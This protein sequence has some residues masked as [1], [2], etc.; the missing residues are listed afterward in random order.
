MDS[1]DVVSLF[2]RR[3][4]PKNGPGLILFGSVAAPAT[5]NVYMVMSVGG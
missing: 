3:R 4:G 5:S 1:L 2:W